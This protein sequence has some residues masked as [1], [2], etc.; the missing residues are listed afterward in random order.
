MRVA[1]TVPL[2]NDVKQVIVTGP[3]F[4]AVSRLEDLGGK[5]VYIN[6]LTVNY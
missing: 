3:N 1:F 2:E 6:P 5:E 4:G